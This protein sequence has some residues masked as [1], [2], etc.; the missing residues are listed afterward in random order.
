M[1]GSQ[2]GSCPR[3]G[4][5]P[6]ELGDTS[7]C[8]TGEDLHTTSAFTLGFTGFGCRRQQPSLLSEQTCTIAGLSAW[9]LAGNEVKKDVELLE[10]VQTRPRG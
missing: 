1:P 2:L 7:R 8:P 3:V 5:G 10:Q 9:T 6:V 4:P